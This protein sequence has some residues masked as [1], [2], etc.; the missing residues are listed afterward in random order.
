MKSVLRNFCRII[1][2]SSRQSSTI[3]VCQ[4][5]CTGDKEA[6]FSACQKIIK[7]ASEAN[8]SI[9]FLPEGCDYIGSSHDETFSLA[10]PIGGP[11][12][13]RFQAVARVSLTTY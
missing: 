12:L 3:A 1:Q 8:A 5:S 6:N 2:M 7:S 4:L 11:F 10:E 9:V 13:Q